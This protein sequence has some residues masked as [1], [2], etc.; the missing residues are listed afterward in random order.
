MQ[1]LNQFVISFTGLKEGEHEYKFEL[2]NEFFEHFDGFLYD[3]F[4]DFLAKFNKPFETQRRYLLL[5]F[6]LVFSLF[7]KHFDRIF[8][9]PNFY[10]FFSPTFFTI[11]LQD[12]VNM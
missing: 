1:F 4:D 7:F 8:K 10:T 6:E 5:S 3:Y 9:M 12:F 2:E 11:F